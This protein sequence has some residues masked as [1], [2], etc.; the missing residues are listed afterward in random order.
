MQHLSSLN[1]WHVRIRSRLQASISNGVNLRRNPACP[2]LAPKQL[3]GL[4]FT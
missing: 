1:G 4:S 3:D 2:T